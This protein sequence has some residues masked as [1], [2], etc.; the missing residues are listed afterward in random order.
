MHTSEIINGRYIKGK[1]CCFKIVGLDLLYNLNSVL[2]K[3]EWKP[4]KV[5]FNKWATMR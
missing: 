3:Q 4:V 5:C 2:K 1:F